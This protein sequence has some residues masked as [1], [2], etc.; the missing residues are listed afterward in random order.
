MNEN[1]KIV[2]IESDDQQVRIDFRYT[3]CHGYGGWVRINPKCY[4]RPAGS[5]ENL[6]LQKTEGIPRAPK[7]LTFRKH[8]DV[9][10]YSLFFPPLPQNILEIDIIE[11]EEDD[12]AFNFY[13]IPLTLKTT[14]MTNT[15]TA[16]LKNIEHISLELKSDKK[17]IKLFNDELNRI[18]NCLSEMADFLNLSKKEAAIFSLATYISISTDCFCAKELK[19]HSNFSPFDFFEIKNIIKSLVKKAWIV[20]SGTQTF[21][22]GSRRVDDT[23][24]A[25]P[26]SIL[27]SLYKNICPEVKAKEMDVYTVS[28]LLHK[29]LKNYCNEDL[30]I[31]EMEAQIKDY[32]QDYAEFNPIKLANELDLNL[33]ERKILY[34]LVSKTINGEEV[35]EAERILANFFGIKAERIIIKKMFSKREG[36]LFE[37]NIIEFVETDF[38]TDSN[39][40]LS[41]EAVKLIFGEDASFLLKEEDFS[42]GIC[43][44]IKCDSIIEKELFY[45]EKE[46]QSISTVSEF[47]KE[48][49]FSEVV[50]RLEENKMRPG[51]TILLHGYAGTG[52]TETIY[53]LAKQTNRD[54]LL[55]DI[56]EIKDKYVGE[57]EK[58]L[59]S[60]FESYKN[61]LK[62]FKQAPILLF[63][64]SDA[65]IG[66]RINV[67]SSV[68]QMNNAMQ[69]ILLQE[70]E[71]FKGILMATTNLTSNL[72][73]A[74][75]RRFLFKI[76]YA[77][78]STVAKKSIWKSKLTFLSDEDAKQLA[79]EFD[80]SGGQ[81]ENISRKIFLDA[82]LHGKT[83]SLHDTIQYCEDEV[84]SNK[85][86]RKIGF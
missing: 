59:K 60:V 31:E 20:K 18:D 2:N 27:E 15:T 79:E 43:K 46:Q 42:S 14:I 17:N 64:E 86:N 61:S 77:K 75:E 12:K 73:E 16:V 71:D 49:K 8:G 10:Y 28:E 39:L 82:I 67:H 37:K 19:S 44:L 65:L 13:S 30:E 74:F 29:C 35:I 36:M 38:R 11:D 51:L 80:F 1:S 22:N 48:E 78:P 63:N 50:K 41:D 72:D 52:K 33:R 9:L 45:N 26:S 24:Y 68:D 7:V 58:R 83:N 6:F 53:Q 66:K 69:N 85:N 56:S 5:D 4:I 54:I 57:S 23:L 3:N 70:L 40:K 34:Y 76:K 25:I 32:E 84:L 62:H 81:I 21:H 55:V 47:L